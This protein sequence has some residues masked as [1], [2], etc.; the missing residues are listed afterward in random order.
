MITNGASD[1]KRGVV[2]SDGIQR[3]GNRRLDRG[4][5]QQLSHKAKKSL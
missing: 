5:M 1:L 3:M 4:G 2:K